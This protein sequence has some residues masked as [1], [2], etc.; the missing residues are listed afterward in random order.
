[1][2]ILNIN[3]IGS[4]L[5]F[6]EYKD[7]D[8]SLINSDVLSRNFGE[9]NDYIEYFIHDLNNN[10]LSFNYNCTNYKI[11]NSDPV[12][13]TGNKLLL[14]P[15][16]DVKDNGY[17]RGSVNI[18]YNFLRKLFNSSDSNKFWIRDISND[19]TEIRVFRQD[20][21]NDVLQQLYTQYSLEVSTKT[22]YPDFYLNF[23]E[24][25]I[26]IGINIAFTLVNE[27]ACLLLKLYEPLPI[28]FTE[29]DTFW[30][31]DKLSEPATYNIDI[32]VAA[33]DII[34][35]DTLRGPNYNIE[36][37]NKTGQTT[38]YL[39]LGKI[40]NNS[41]T[42][43]YN[44]LKS[45]IGEKG[46]DINV[47]Y[48]NFNNFIHFSSAVERITNFAYKMQLIE[49]YSADITSLNT[50]SNNVNTV[51]SSVS[52]IQNKINDIVEKFD[53]YEYY[54][55]F[56][57]GSSAWP[58]SNQK[59]P[60]QLYSYSSSQVSDWLGGINTPPAPNKQS[61]L[62]S[63]SY[64]DV[65]NKDWLL[66][67]IPTYLK[68]DPNNEPY[69]IFLSMIGQHFDN[70][71]IYAKGIT[72]RYNAQNNINKGVSKDEIADALKSLGIKLYTNTNISDNIF[73]SLIGIG[74][75]GQTLPPTGSEVIN[76]YVTSSQ[77]TMPADDITAEYYKRLYHN[78]P[79]LLKT[80]GTSTGLRAL[81]NCF[82][83]PDTILRINEFG[84]SDKLQSTP[85]LIQNDFMTSY[86]NKDA[87]YIKA[88]WGPSRYQFIKTGNKNIVPDTI[89]FN[90]RNIDG[91]P[92]NALYYTQSLFQV[93]KNTDLQFGVN[94]QYNP[95]TNPVSS[96]NKFNGK[97]RLYIS[98][99]QGFTQSEP[100]ELP[101]FDPTQWWTLMVKR[102]VGG[103]DSLN[104]NIN[105]TYSLFVKNSLYNQNGG[106]NIGFQASSSIFINGSVS[107]SYNSSW[108]YY[109]TSSEDT[110]FS[111]YIGGFNNNN[112]LSQ[113]G[114]T[115]Q[116]L[117]HD[118]R[119]WTEPLSESIFQQHT[120][121]INSYSGNNPTSSLFNLIFRLPLEN[122]KS[123]SSN[124]T[125]IITDY[126]YNGG[127]IREYE[128][129][130][131]I[132]ESYHPTVSGSYYIPESEIFANNI[133]S[134]ISGNTDINYGL[135]N[136]TGSKHFITE[137]RYNLI[138]TPS[139]GLSQRV[140]NKINAN[141]SVELTDKLL[142]RDNTLQ[143][144]NSEISKNS[145]DIEVGFSPSE[146]INTDIINQLGY[147]NIDDYIGAPNNQYADEYIDLN[148]LK[149]T[150]FQKYQ[151]S[152]KLWDFVRLLKYYDNSLFKMIKDFVPAKSNLS[153]GVIVK[154]H[155]LERSKYKRNE[156][157]FTFTQYSSSLDVVSVSGSNP[158]GIDI[159]T[160]YTNFITT[161]IGYIENQNNN[162]Q[163]LYTGELGGTEL[164]P[165]EN[166]FNQ[167]EISKIQT[168]DNSYFI[169]YSLDP[170]LNNVSSSKKSKTIL[171][172][173]YT[174]N[175]NIPTN[176]IVIN[177]AFNLYD[178]RLNNF[179]D[180]ELDNKTYPFAEIEDS[181]YNTYSYN[182]IRY[183]GSK[184]FSANYNQ[185]TPPRI[186][187]VGDSSYGKTAAIDH[188]VKKLGLFTS[189]E[190]SSFFTNKNNVLLT[191]LVD[192]E[193]NYT[194]LD[195]NLL[196][197]EE[198]QNTF[199]QGFTT[200]K[201]FDA[202]QFSNQTYTN[203]KKNIYNSGYSYDPL[204]YYTSRSYTSDTVST[205]GDSE[206]SFE[207]IGENQTQL[208]NI[209]PIQG[210]I[211][212]GTDNQ[213]NNY[214]T[215]PT[216]S[217]SYYS[218]YSLFNF[219]GR[220]DEYND[221]VFTPSAAVPS[222]PPILNI[223]NGKFTSRS[224]NVYSFISNFKVLLNFGLEDTTTEIIYKINKTVGTSPGN[225]LSITKT[226]TS[227]ETNTELNQYNL[228]IAGYRYRLI[229]LQ[230]QNKVAIGDTIVYDSFGNII[231]QIPESTPPLVLE[232]FTITY[233][234]T[235]PTEFSSR[236][237]NNLLEPAIPEVVND[238]GKYL[239][240][241]FD[242]L[243]YKVG[244]FFVSDPG[245]IGT[246]VSSTTLDFNTALNGIQ[247]DENDELEFELL[248]TKSTLDNPNITMEILDG[249]FIRNT[250]FEG[251]QT[252]EPPFINF[253][254]ERNIVEITNGL[255]NIYGGDYK[256]VPSGSGI[257]ESSLFSRFGNINYTFRITQGD[258]LLLTQ[259]N[260]K[261]NSEHTV[262][263]VLDVQ[264]NKTIVKVNPALPSGINN[265]L[266]TFLILKK[267]QDE[268]NI[269][270]N[271]KKNPGKTSYGL[272]IPNN[273][274]PEILK[275]IDNISKEIQAK[276]I[277]NQI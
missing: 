196:N 24:N 29:K 144:Y 57:S 269:I 138:T 94:I 235:Q 145:Q 215:F 193:G 264:N 249:G 163:E 251:Y 78:L 250:L 71:W 18:T 228:D 3:Y 198:V 135:P 157:T 263:Y 22:Y 165:V 116:G 202:N 151:S 79:Y 173:D 183:E 11:A 175:P 243:I 89:E 171:D 59:Q 48:T 110:T 2:E 271:F 233:T 120:Q 273:I 30:I 12:F 133:G 104:P 201:L 184:T 225:K 162:K 4:N 33:E 121:N 179:N 119:Y 113:N 205:Q 74:P 61:I 236:A 126:N 16:L 86:W 50:I 152:Y 254:T 223:F 137:Q 155:I 55:Y 256:F 101:F 164:K 169:T 213:L 244:N 72:N 109:N 115:F 207:Y 227:K 266:N 111:G 93:G 76:T 234:P 131:S 90:F 52:L 209:S 182:N 139:T 214:D 253:D 246:R 210:K 91:I 238:G 41:T 200:V 34:T 160:N 167:F 134:I 1:M 42:S 268:N 192:R 156:P 168:P 153:T 56:E 37:S 54:L 60:Y 185:Y 103:E 274:D 92:N 98:G 38:E 77:E 127:I 147:F 221:N 181:I 9:Q 211:I 230:G 158:Q 75:S 191:Y 231:Q 272:L 132:F 84:G 216:Y 252:I 180:T 194:N 123:I 148:E 217:N 35:R 150:Y 161:S 47:D 14:N 8:L 69:Q 99:T 81:I 262:E 259:G 240:G 15:D 130:K 146:N 31:V 174:Y 64:H 53:G 62:Y 70:I 277:T 197:W 125:S 36:I 220:L 124:N 66:N 178:E 226:F 83:I 49:G 170:V 212:P 218:V 143:I 27:Q 88:P 248:V 108:N 43:S 106:N 140:N 224:S 199:K 67:T 241:S 255:S 270:L 39:S 73:Y 25:K 46:Y 260:N 63:A 95:I 68:D 107:S 5:E 239:L 258:V 187:Y 141:T 208:F 44:Q 257:P 129:S 190:S 6:Q 275:N 142:S 96:N 80:K 195:N 247:L 222:T 13:N 128:V 219:T 97:L 65:N 45:V 267:I 51:S 58:K 206:V 87:E 112:V 136:I 117:I 32:Q 26:I 186:N 189:I 154:P 122:N 82:G 176:N 118:F 19:R 229:S 242:L 159:N 245:D 204:F 114:V 203:G 40:F 232:A 105:N 102:E 21:P 149:K 17:D 188:Y 276:L 166:T 20:I 172:I 28:T 23:G 85:D 100:I 10:L 177:N 261:I 7:K 265:N 237:A